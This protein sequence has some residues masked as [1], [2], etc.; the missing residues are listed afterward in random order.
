MEVL[1]LHAALRVELGEFSLEVSLDLRSD[2][3]GLL[4]WYKSNESGLRMATKSSGQVG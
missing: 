2:I 4:R 3:I 1:D